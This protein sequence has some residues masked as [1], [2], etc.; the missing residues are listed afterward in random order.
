MT[1]GDIRSAAMM[2]GFT[3]GLYQFFTADQL[4]SWLVAIS[5]GLCTYIFFRLLARI[6]RRKEETLREYERDDRR[7]P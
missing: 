1:E 2:S 4:T 6:E 3:S 5:A 7:G